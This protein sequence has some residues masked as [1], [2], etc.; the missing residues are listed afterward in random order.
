[1]GFTRNNDLSEEEAGKVV[2]AY[3]MLYV[4]SM[5][6]DAD[7]SLFQEASES[8]LAI[9]PTW[10]DTQTFVKE[11]RST[12]LSDVEVRERATWNSTLKVLEE[13]GERYGR[14]QDTECHALKTTL[15]QMEE[16]GTG[17]VPLERFYKSA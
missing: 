5:G 1:M 13:V 2:E 7:N 16:P 15:I 17:R 8:I 11:V 4:L 14:W 12:V 9:Y 10:P 3:M 6:N